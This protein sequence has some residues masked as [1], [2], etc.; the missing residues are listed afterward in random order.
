MKYLKLTI[1][2][3]LLLIALESEAEDS[4]LDIKDTMC[5]NEESIYI[6]CSFNVSGHSKI[7]SAS[8][9]AK[10]NKS[11]TLGYVQ[12]RYGTPNDEIEF[13]YPHI[14]TPP[15]GIFKIYERNKIDG[16]S[17]ALQFSNGSYHYSFER[18]GLSGYRLVVR[19]HKE[20]IFD[21]PCDPP[22]RNYLSDRAHT[23][24]GVVNEPGK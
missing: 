3:S 24:I 4:F 8:I 5:K 20:K 16:I 19:H 21:K 17:S 6:S 22:G 18:I 10:G 7:K 1:I 13:E 14:K 2:K 12:Y 9:C 15:V 11:P 23:G